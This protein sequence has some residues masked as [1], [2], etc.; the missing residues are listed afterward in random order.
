MGPGSV[1]E[2]VLLTYRAE[3]QGVEL[4]CPDCN[5]GLVEA[6]GLI[7]NL[8]TIHHTEG[9]RGIVFNNVGDVAVATALLQ[10]AATDIVS[11]FGEVPTSSYDVP[12]MDPAKVGREILGE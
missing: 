7:L 10:R 3:Q 6:D 12:Y 8:W 1:E 5:D 11:R 4:Y 2:Y 9:S